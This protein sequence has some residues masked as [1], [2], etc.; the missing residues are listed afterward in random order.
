M[1]VLLILWVCLIGSWQEPVLAQTSVSAIFHLNIQNEHHTKP[2]IPIQENQEE[3]DDLTDEDEDFSDKPL[4]TSVY[5]FNQTFLAQ[6]QSD[7]F[8]LIGKSIGHINPIVTP[9]E[10]LV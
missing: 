8:Y 4:T 3:E 9:P 7:K 6:H 1:R 5:T 10:R 2:R